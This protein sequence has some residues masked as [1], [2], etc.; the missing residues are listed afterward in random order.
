MNAGINVILT[1]NCNLVN[2]L[3]IILLNSLILSIVAF[4]FSLKFQKFKQIF[5]FLIISTTLYNNIYD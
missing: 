3:K 4:G 1:L 5:K 2:F